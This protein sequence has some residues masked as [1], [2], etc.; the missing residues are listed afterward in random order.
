[1]FGIEVPQEIIL[2]RGY[3]VRWYGAR[4]IFNNN[5]KTFDI[6]WDRQSSSH[7][8][9]LEIQPLLD[10]LNKVAFPKLKELV[11][12]LS[13]DSN[14]VVDFKD[15]QFTLQASPNSS[16]GYLYIGAWQYWPKDCMYEQ[17]NPT[18]DAQWRGKVPIPTIGQC[19]KANMNGQ[20][21]GEV[22]AYFV[23]CGYQGVE[24]DCSGKNGTTPEFYKKQH[25]DPKRVL[26]FG[27]DL[28]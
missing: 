25:G 13:W 22:T 28:I 4:A 6:V 19:I 10:W 24:V 17:E 8:N 11:K 5:K 12:N 18:S 21:Q 23:E 20:W 3:P 16:Y 15:K 14:E 27:C 9:G 2:E 26:L 1:M 7:M